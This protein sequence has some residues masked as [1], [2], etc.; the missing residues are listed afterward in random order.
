MGKKLRK[1]LFKFIKLI[2]KKLKPKILGR[3]DQIRKIKISKFKIKL[4]YA[5]T[6]QNILQNIVKNLETA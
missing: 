1:K 6:F 5:V 4:K 3:S 2:K